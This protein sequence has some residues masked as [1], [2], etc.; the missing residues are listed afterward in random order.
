M[1]DS[2]NF[3]GLK[4]SGQNEAMNE[5]G[6]SLIKQDSKVKTLTSAAN[7]QGELNALESMKKAKLLNED[8]SLYDMKVS[9]GGFFVAVDKDGNKIT[10]YTDP[11][12]NILGY[13]KQTVDP[14]TK[15][16][17]AGIKS[18]HAPDG[19][20]LAKTED[21]SNQKNYQNTKDL[22][23]MTDY[24]MENKGAAYAGLNQK[25]IED[26]AN[27]KKQEDKENIIKKFL[28]DTIE[29]DAVLKQASDIPVVIAKQ[30]NTDNM[31]SLGE[32]KENG[33][34]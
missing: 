10:M 27:A 13:E 24:T 26:M 9:A 33:T 3:E 15:D 12:G 17:G 29:T 28:E 21:G 32:V 11:K 5:V 2:G 19:R 16:G 14:N 1:S 34:N 8:V 18:I 25:F 20:I 7:S 23:V 4:I 31:P 30:A 6:D 22:R